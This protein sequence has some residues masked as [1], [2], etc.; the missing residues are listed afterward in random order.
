MAGV[1]QQHGGTYKVRAVLSSR[2]SMVWRRWLRGLTSLGRSAA[3]AEIVC[4]SSN[5]I[6]SKNTVSFT[7]GRGKVSRLQ[8]RVYPF[9]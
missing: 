8:G 5:D 3:R 6:H 9:P 2:V 1:E 7:A 4:A